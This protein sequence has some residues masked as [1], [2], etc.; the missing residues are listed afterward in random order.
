MHGDNPA[1]ASGCH[2]CI[3]AAQTSNYTGSQRHLV[4]LIVLSPNQPTQVYPDARIAWA[5]VRMLHLW[6]Q[7][8]TKPVWVIVRMLHLW[9]QGCQTCMGYSQ[10]VASVVARV[11]NLYG[12]QSGRCICGCKGAKVSLEPGSPPTLYRIRNKKGESLEDFDHVLD[13]VGHG[14]AWSRAKTEVLT[15]LCPP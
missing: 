15:D 1:Q 4:A 8:G 10:D 9:L 13:M 5:T 2:D 3:G 12:L 7:E 11:P 14:W 6:L